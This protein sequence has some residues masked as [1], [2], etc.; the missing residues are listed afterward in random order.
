M[1]TLSVDI[2]N[3]SISLGLFK[4]GELVYSKKISQ[5][6]FNLRK[7]NALKKKF[8][9]KDTKKIIISSVV[10]ECDFIFKKFLTDNLLDFYFLKKL[11]K[12]INLKINLKKK[13]E[14]GDDRIANIIFAK[15][16]FNKSII[17]VDFGTATT[18][19]VLNKFGVYHGGVITPGI[20]VSLNTLKNKTAKLPLVKFAKTT[21]VVGFNTRE[22]IQSGFFWGYCSMIEGLIR[23][24]IKE[25]NDEFNIVLTGGNASYFNNIFENVILIDEFFTSK[26]L[27]FILNKYT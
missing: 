14:I 22:A 11:R 7:L 5:D 25:Q 26:A 17:I 4:D 24:I 16:K 10:P 8:F 2:G 12:K 27:N 13:S 19:D 20:E 23:R 15:E 1:K 6:G 3:T 18:L 9:N 21:R